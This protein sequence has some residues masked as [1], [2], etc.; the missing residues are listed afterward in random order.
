MIINKVFIMYGEFTVHSYMQHIRALNL[1]QILLV[2]LRWM[3]CAKNTSYLVFSHTHLLVCPWQSAVAQN[4]RLFMRCPQLR[5]LFTHL[6]LTSH[7][8][9][10]QRW[11]LITSWPVTSSWQ[12]IHS[13]HY[14]RVQFNQ[15]KVPIWRRFGHWYGSK[16]SLVR[17][18]GPAF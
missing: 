12:H 14:G 13:T 9:L 7:T 5:D 17:W 6:P 4:G 11:G 15:S 16:Q 18:L 2:N 8:W 1:L 10:T 3:F